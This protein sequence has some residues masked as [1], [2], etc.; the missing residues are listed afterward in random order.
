MMR[1]IAAMDARHGIATDDGIP[2][3]LPTDQQFFA[4]QT[5]EGIILMGRHTYAEVTAP[6]H[7]RTNY[8]GTRY[9]GPLRDGFVPVADVPAFLREH[10]DEVVQNIG[11]AALFASTLPLAD[12]LVLTRID[13]DFG[14]TRFFPEFADSFELTRESDPVTEHGSTFTFQWWHPR[15]G[16]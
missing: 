8:V 3:T 10:R 5:A 2:W 11:G 14:C 1:M 4:D 16:S 9:A 12:E 13:G 7:D 15:R 6:L